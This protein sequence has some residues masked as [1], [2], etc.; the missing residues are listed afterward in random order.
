VKG[1]DDT[2]IGGDD[3]T[4]VPLL[5]QEDVSSESEPGELPVAKPSSSSLTAD[6][7]MCQLKNIKNEVNRLYDDFWSLV[8]SLVL[9]THSP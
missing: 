4:A 6:S 7:A 5:T 1:A 8:L 3:S 2:E 9:L